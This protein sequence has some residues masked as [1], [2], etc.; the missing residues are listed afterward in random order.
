MYMHSKG[1]EKE[2]AGEGPVGW[3]GLISN[4]QERLRELLSLAKQLLYY[5][6]NWSVHVRTIWDLIES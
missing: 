2:K 4:I 1:M 3:I 6:N 5:P